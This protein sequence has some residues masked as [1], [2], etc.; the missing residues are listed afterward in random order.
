MGDVLRRLTAF[1]CEGETLLGT[2]DEADG[3]TG[4]LIVSGGAE[5]RAGAHRGMARLAAGLAA[6]GHPVFRFDRRG[7]G[8]STGENR[9]H[10]E[11]G[12]DLRAAATCFREGTPSLKRL[13]ALGNCDAA[14][15][16]TLFGREAGLDALILTNP[17]LDG[18]GYPELPPAPAIRA[19]YLARLRD[20]ASWT[21]PPNISK[22]VR[23]LRALL[24]SDARPELAALYAA[25]P[26]PTT[27]ILADRDPTAQAF[28]A[29]TYV[30]FVRIPTAS[31]SF[32]DA[33]DELE[34]AVVAALE[35]YS[36][37]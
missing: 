8:D 19:R 28:M 13:V 5:V 34:A 17:W 6:R 9:G 35:R 2:L 7:V 16:L 4:L 33:A 24:R 29:A 21:R 14:A 31:H 37:A 18:A 27:F 25:P 20:P 15:A 26:L 12:P 1:P 32:A 30:S 10:L 22:L 3:D 36:A 11:S 23:G